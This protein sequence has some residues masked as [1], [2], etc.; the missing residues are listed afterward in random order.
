VGV[1]IQ[2]AVPLLDDLRR[3]EHEVLGRWFVGSGVPSGNDG[4]RISADLAGSDVND[5]TIQADL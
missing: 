2:Q 4:F 5:L 1:R 3:L